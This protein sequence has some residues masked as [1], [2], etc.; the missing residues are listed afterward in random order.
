[1]MM[2]W[3]DKKEQFELKLKA[4]GAFNYDPIMYV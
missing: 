1:M 2:I 3:D 4:I